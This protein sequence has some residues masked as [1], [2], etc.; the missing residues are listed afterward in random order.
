MAPGPTEAYA[1]MTISSGDDDIRVLMKI[2][3]CI[4]DG[5]GIPEYLATKVAITIFLRK[6]RYH[7][8]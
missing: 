4:L 3:H 8:L 5:K 7:E 1:K 2:Y 6:R